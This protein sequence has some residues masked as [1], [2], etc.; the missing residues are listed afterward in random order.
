MEIAKNTKESQKMR[1]KTD[2]SL[3]GERAKINAYLEQGER[4]DSHKAEEQIRSTRFEADRARELARTEHDQSKQDEAKSSR[5]RER[6]DE[7]TAQ[8]LERKKVDEILSK[9]RLAKRLTA[10]ALLGTERKRTDEH[11]GGERSA[12]DLESEQKDALLSVEQTANE[13]AKAAVDLRD[14]FLGMVSHDL[15]NPLGVIIGCNHLMQQD[16]RDGRIDVK[17]LLHH[18]E[19]IDRN[20]AYMDRMITDLLDIKRIAS[21]KLI[22]EKH[23]CD[24]N[25]LLQECKDLFD[26]I[27]EEKSL[28]LT[29]RSGAKQ[30]FANIDHDRILEVLSNL[31]GNAIKFTPSQGNITLALQ[32]SPTEVEVSVTDT[33]P[34]VPEEKKFQIFEKFSQVENQES[35]G[36]GLGLFISKWIVEAHKGRLWVDSEVGKGSRFTFTLPIAR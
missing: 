4:S 27:V 36:L 7:D 13:F 9:E 14:R 32:E 28:S 25:G 8:A 20:A 30:V 31:I 2:K 34:G 1:V 21:G 17:S 19:V 18:T 22:L 24:I 29:V 11:L 6:K 33:G 16:L 10:E 5:A 12:Y 3:K 26:S 23:R 15:K 35:R